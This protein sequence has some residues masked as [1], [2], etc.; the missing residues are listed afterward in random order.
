M[1]RVE[2]ISSVFKYSPFSYQKRAAELADQIQEKNIT[3]SGV[4][5]ASFEACK[6][7]TAILT[8]IQRLT[9]ILNKKL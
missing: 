4:D 6:N 5:L 1:S 2:P 7:G 8:D 3:L 9:D